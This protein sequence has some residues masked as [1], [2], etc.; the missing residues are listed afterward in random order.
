[1]WTLT[2]ATSLIY[3]HCSSMR[4]TR[5]RGMYVRNQI[6][7]LASLQQYTWPGSNWRPSAC[8]ADVIAT[9]P[10]VPMNLA[11]DLL[12][13]IDAIANNIMLLTLGAFT[14]NASPGISDTLA[15]WLRRRPAKPMGSPRVG[16]NPTGVDFQPA[17]TP[18][19][20]SLFAPR[21]LQAWRQ[22]WTVWGLSPGP[23][24]C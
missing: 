20:R 15:E 10:Q 12:S 11:L 3:C 13:V 23:P 24:A 6:G 5:K 18:P 14:S 17:G 21:N 4:A 8:W 9:R 1:M 19:G 7:H 22:K 16:S 2:N